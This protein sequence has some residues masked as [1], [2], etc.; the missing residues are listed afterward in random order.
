MTKNWNYYKLDLV[1][2]KDPETSDFSF[3]EIDKKKEDEYNRFLEKMEK[4]EKRE[5]NW[6]PYYPNKDMEWMYGSYSGL[7]ISF[8]V[9]DK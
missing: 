3:D 8:E 6:K 4:F 2:G 9:Y 7:Y 1:E 5:I